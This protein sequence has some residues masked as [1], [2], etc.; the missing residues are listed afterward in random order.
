MVL[1]YSHS[2]RKGKKKVKA[3][4]AALIGYLDVRRLAGRIL[5]TWRHCGMMENV[6]YVQGPAQVLVIIHHLHVSTVSLSKGWRV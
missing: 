5:E 4:D 2:Q 3:V 6:S 1:G